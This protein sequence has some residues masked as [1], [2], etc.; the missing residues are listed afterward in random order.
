MKIHEK[1]SGQVND[2]IYF[3]F[4]GAQRKLNDLLQDFDLQR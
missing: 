1:V 3:R 4:F 2:L